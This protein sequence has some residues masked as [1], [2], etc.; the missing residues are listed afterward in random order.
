M[1]P[2]GGSVSKMEPDQVTIEELKASD[3]QIVVHGREGPYLM[4]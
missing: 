2:G 4:D 3:T 1:T